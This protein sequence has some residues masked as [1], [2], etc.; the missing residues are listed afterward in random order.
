MVGSDSCRF[1]RAANAY[2]AALIC[3]SKTPSHQPER[4]HA[5]Q[6]ATVK[7]RVRYLFLTMIFDRVGFLTWPGFLESNPFGT[8]I[9]P[10]RIDTNRNAPS[11]LAVWVAL[12]HQRAR[13]PLIFN[14]P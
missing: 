14:L 12:G 7:K 8:A 10:F 11:G 9:S 1:S 6:A 13:S 2:P 3:R 4:H 5:Y